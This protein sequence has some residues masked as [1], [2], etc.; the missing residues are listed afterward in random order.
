[1]SIGGI[2]MYIIFAALSYLFIFDKE[3]E[4]DPRVSTHFCPPPSLKVILNI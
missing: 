1:M 2:F 4:K 3:F